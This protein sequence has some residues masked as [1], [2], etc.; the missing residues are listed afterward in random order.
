MRCARIISDSRSVPRRDLNLA[1]TL[2]PLTIDQALRLAIGHHRAGHIPQA[3]AIYLQVLKAEPNQPD[4]LHML[5]MLAHQTGESAIAAER[6][7]RAIR[8]KPSDPLLH[9]NLGAIFT[10]LNRLDEAA[11]CFQ[12][13]LA[14]KQDFAEAHNNLGNIFDA[15][16]EL[17]QAAACYQ[18]AVAS[19]PDFAEAHYNLGRTLSGLGR[20]EE[21]MAS[22][23]KAVAFRPDFAEAHNNLGLTMHD[24]ADLDAAV[25]CYRKA[26][27][28][29]PDYAEAHNNLGRTLERQHKV[30]EAIRSYERALAIRPDFAEAHNN[31]GNAFDRQG[32]LDK[33]IACYRKA[34]VLKPEY[35]EAYNNLG[36]ALAGKGSH[37][38]AI[39]CYQ[40]ALAL[41]PDYA[42]AHSHL[43][44]ALHD[45]GE[46]DAAIACYRKAL[47]LKPEF[48]GAHNN[49]GRALAG[50]RK[51][52]EAVACYRRA[53]AL[54]PDFALAL[55]NLGNALRDRGEL[56]EA[57]SCCLRAI[58]LEPEFAEAH[59]NLANALKDQGKLSAAIARYRKALELKPDFDWVNGNLLLALQY[60]PECSPT[61]L[62][63]EHRRFA[64][65][66]EV[67]LESLRQALGNTRE[68][69][70]RLKVGYVS[71]DFRRHSVAY[72]IEP[73]LA[74]HDKSQVE[75]FC[76]YNQSTQDDLTGRIIA[77]ADHWIPCVG[78]TDE[79]LAARIRADGVD[80]LVDLAGHTA[81]NRLLVFAR[82]PA[83]VQV[84]WLGYPST[85]GLSAI[86]YR[87][88]DRHAEPPGMTEQ[89]SVEKLWR[90]GMFCVYR[91][92]AVK[93]E[94]RHS[95]EL[96]V[97]PTP[98]LENGYITFGSINNIAKITP[99]VVAVW[100]R[101]LHAVP[102]ARLLL[103]TAGFDSA[104]MRADF[105]ARFAA[106]GVTQDRLV[107]LERKPEQQ[108]VLYHRIDIALDPFP[109]NGGTTTCDALWMGVPV[110]ALAGTTFA[111]RMGVT[112]VT[113]AG[114]PEWVARDEDGYLRLACEL[115]SDAARLNAIRLGLRDEAER[116]A[117]RDEAGFTRRLE[118]AYRG[119]WLEW[120]ESCNV[121]PERKA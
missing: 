91:P 119:M 19:R 57:V 72:F 86:D 83:P 115:A 102:G 89:Y 84:T 73:V 120:C 75:V 87:I 6:I 8:H 79:Q 20:T 29:K 39:A 68:P 59:S 110:I 43:G 81:G 48:A 112:M 108:Y 37:D 14:L 15:R 3:E 27:E 4:A 106:H 94:R 42:E 118:A 65:R 30:D 28:L 99:A 56:D 107:L 26:L 23:Q 101:I 53:L 31:L 69:G 21:A 63:E 77:H 24:K 45:K 95:P 50:L 67:P 71:A 62:Y 52:D 82:K 55:S 116:S 117:L 66:F 32:Y 60:D 1:Q 97:R 25:A 11:A 96:A 40:K 104:G 80:I 47:A 34:I 78:M 9:F 90:L 114:H 46:A 7:S 5:G 61:E 58:E 74:S 64:Q 10:T 36:V 103:E 54:Q 17:G 51:L 22:Y 92:C 105:E 49:L 111:A 18:S 76:Y 100:A 93:P 44:N 121:T 16:G 2:Q 113:N 85:T 41:K 12:K 109:C 70:R 98:A 88:T 33:A 38:D 13:A 35:A